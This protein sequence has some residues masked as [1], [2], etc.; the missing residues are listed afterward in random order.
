MKNI[1]I[2]LLVLGFAKNTLAGVKY[3]NLPLSDLGA[4]SLKITK[5]QRVDKIDKTDQTCIQIIDYAVSNDESLKTDSIDFKKNASFVFKS[6][7]KNLTPLVSVQL[8]PVRYYLIIDH[9]SGEAHSRTS[10]ALEFDLNL[11]GANGQVF[12]KSSESLEI[13]LA[14]LV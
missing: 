5:S 11:K 12:H 8:V 10:K 3:E 2:I 7:C 14:I 13:H 4:L 6:A 9:V 1:F